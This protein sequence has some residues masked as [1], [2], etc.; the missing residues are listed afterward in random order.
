[1]G[2]QKQQQ[3]PGTGGHCDWVARQTLQSL[4]RDHVHRQKHVSQMQ[5]DIDAKRSQFLF[6]DDLRSKQW[7]DASYMQPCVP[8]S[9]QFNMAAAS[10]VSS[11]GVPELAEPPRSSL[12]HKIQQSMQ[13]RV[14]DM[15][16]LKEQQHLQ[17]PYV[18]KERCN[19]LAMEDARREQDRHRSLC[20]PVCGLRSARDEFV[21]KSKN[22]SLYTQEGMLAHA[23]K[24]Q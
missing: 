22:Q 5:A 24:S 3:M 15:S 21:Q 12:Q 13:Q 19:F 1:M 14:R 17:T 18:Y 9:S 16:S 6:A 7:P 2:G 10:R 20:Q 11:A 4:S 23:L 8:T